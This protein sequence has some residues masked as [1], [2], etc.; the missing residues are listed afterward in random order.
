MQTSRD[1]ARIQIPVKQL[2]VPRRT[3]HLLLVLA[4][5]GLAAS[6]SL[7]LLLLLQEDQ[8]V[9]LVLDGVLRLDGLLNLLTADQ[10]G[11]DGGTDHEGQDEAVHAVPVGST[12][13]GGGAGVV[14][15]QESEG[16]ELGDQSVLGGEQQSRPGHGR[17]NDTG[18]VT[19]VAELAAV[20]RPLKTPVDSTEE[21][22]DLYCQE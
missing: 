19:A 13:G 3:P 16:K 6:L 17:G 9:D 11:H 15:V 18:S 8:S 5:L 12:A 22:E 2:Q 20:A 1:N 14:V 10:G 21:G 4:E 7:L